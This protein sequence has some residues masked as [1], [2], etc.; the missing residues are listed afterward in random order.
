M[1]YTQTLTEEAHY[2]LDPL[3]VIWKAKVPGTLILGVMSGTDLKMWKSHVFPLASSGARPLSFLLHQYLTLQP[4]ASCQ[5]HQ[6]RGSCWFFQE[7]C[8]AGSLTHLVSPQTPPPQ[9]GS[10][11]AVLWRSP[12]PLVYSSSCFA[13][14]VASVTTY[15]HRCVACLFCHLEYKPCERSLIAYTDGT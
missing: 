11:P 1:V 10:P 3:N 2:V 4:Q 14:S 9:R 6:T 5:Q 12:T 15:Y 8:M 7:L 13:S